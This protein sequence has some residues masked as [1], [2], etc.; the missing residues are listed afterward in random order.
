MYISSFLKHFYLDHM[1]FKKPDV[2]DND[3]IVILNGVACLLSEPL[4]ELKNR[5]TLLY[6]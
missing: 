6:A 1:V 4:P 5:R 2:Q 3:N